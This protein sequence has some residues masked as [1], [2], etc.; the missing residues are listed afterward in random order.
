MLLPSTPQRFSP[1]DG[2]NP[3]PRGVGGVPGRE[4]AAISGDRI[5][6]ETWH[7]GNRG[8]PDPSA[9]PLRLSLGRPQ[10]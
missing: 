6:K 8:L 5:P 9:P 1:V 4:I 7:R 10:A 2:L 3:G